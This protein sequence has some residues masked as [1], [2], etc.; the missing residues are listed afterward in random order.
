MRSTYLPRSFYSQARSRLL[1]IDLPRSRALLTLTVFPALSPLSA[2]TWRRYLHLCSIIRFSSRVFHRL[3]F[4][5]PCLV[6]APYVLRSSSIG[7]I[8][9]TSAKD[10]RASSIAQAATRELRPR[11]LNEHQ[12]VRP[13]AP[14]LPTDLLTYL[15][16]TT[17]LQPTNYSAPP[18]PPP[19]SLPLMPFPL[20]RRQSDVKVTPSAPPPSPAPRSHTPSPLPS[21][22]FPRFLFTGPIHHH[23]HLAVNLLLAPVPIIIIRIRAPPQKK[24]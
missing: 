17:P 18:T 13:L 20:L 22:L 21:L 9:P 14:G 24:L 23:H 7:R 19:P 1:R 4:Q 15:L 5:H 16:T 12:N 8:F 3:P 10:G 2:A 11:D 6:R